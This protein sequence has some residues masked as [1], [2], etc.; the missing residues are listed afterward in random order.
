MEVSL[1]K[2]SAAVLIKL[3]PMYRKCYKTSLLIHFLNAARVC[4][5]SKWKRSNPL[6]L[7]QWP[8][9]VNNI[10]TLENLASALKDRTAEHTMGLIY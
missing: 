5:H 7:S 3:R 1:S 6:T 10:Q 8:V 9:M 4:S 2:N